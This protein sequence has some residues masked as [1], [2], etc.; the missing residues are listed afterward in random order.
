MNDELKAMIGI[1]SPIK[2]DSKPKGT[3]KKISE[4]AQFLPFTM[5][6][7]FT[8]ISRE[9]SLVLILGTDALSRLF[10][11]LLSPFDIHAGETCCCSTAEVLKSWKKAT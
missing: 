9:P 1:F 7:R 8:G 2:F 5:Y 4:N 11:S 6:M 10:S 3:S